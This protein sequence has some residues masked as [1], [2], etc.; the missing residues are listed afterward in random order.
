MEERIMRIKILCGILIIA[1]S[2]LA[3]CTCG[4]DDDDND[5]NDASPDDDAADDDAAGDDD[6]ATAPPEAPYDPAE[7][8]LFVAAWYADCHLDLEVDNIP[9]TAVEAQANCEDFEM[10]FWICALECFDFY[11]SD[12]VEFYQCVSQC[13]A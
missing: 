4:D 3:A 7:C 10:A 5:D 11:G 12:C 8:A 9:L 13:A 2:W 6:D 1:L